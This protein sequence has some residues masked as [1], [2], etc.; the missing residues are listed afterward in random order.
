MKRKKKI[1]EIVMFEDTVK[2][3]LNYTPKISFDFFINKKEYI[4]DICN[5]NN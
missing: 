5:R 3:I 4:I 2:C 1:V